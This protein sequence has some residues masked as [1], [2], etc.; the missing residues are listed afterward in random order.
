MPQAQQRKKL[1]ALQPDGE[2]IRWNDAFSRNPSQNQ[3]KSRKS[4]RE[5]F[6][7]CPTFMSSVDFRF[8][9]HIVPLYP[10]SSYSQDLSVPPVGKDG[11]RR[12]VV[13][14][15]GSVRPQISGG[16][17]HRWRCVNKSCRKW[18]RQ[19]LDGDVLPE[20]S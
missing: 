16:N 9:N 11:I 12:C 18:Y 15:D 8:M 5:R 7:W 2:L 3:R 13:C 6:V 17:K 1:L 20:V 14:S 4:A 19:V 10:L